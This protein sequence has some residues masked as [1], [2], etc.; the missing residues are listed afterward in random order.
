MIVMRALRERGMDISVAYYYQ[1][2]DP[3]YTFDEADDFRAEG[4]LLSVSP[5]NWTHAIDQLHHEVVQRGI[6]L[7]LQIG[8]PWAYRQLPYLKERC[9]D[10]CLVDTLYNR[11][12]NALNYFLYEN[13]FDGVIVES[14]DMRRFIL[15]NTRKAEPAVH[16]VES[17]IDLDVLY[18]SCPAAGAPFT[19]CYLGRMSQEK[20]P[21]G[22]VELAEQLHPRIPELRF[23][24]FGE[25]PQAET[26]HARIKASAAQTMLRY[27]GYAPLRE[28]LASLHALVVPSRMDGRP[29][30]VMEANACGVPVIGAPVGGIPELITPGR[31]GLLLKPAQLDEIAAAITGWM[32]Q[33]ALYNALRASCRATAEERFDRKRMFDR[34]ENVFRSFLK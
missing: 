4:R 12:H 28:S 26:V 19:I 8:S 31:N 21:I 20:N 10:L 17:G 22:F 5:T 24:M 15:E 9:Q 16:L 3:G 32:S 23:R 13:T 18:P 29:N 27:C 2:G 11:H 14:E 34:Y 6:G 33:P 30:V 25:G 7:L 1:K